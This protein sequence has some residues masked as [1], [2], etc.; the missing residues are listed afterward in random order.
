V[1]DCRRAVRHDLELAAEYYLK[2]LDSQHDDR[3]ALVA[4]E[5]IYRETND[6]ES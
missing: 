2:V 3:R 4:L 5:S 6:V 1:A